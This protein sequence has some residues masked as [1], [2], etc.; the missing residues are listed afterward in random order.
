MSSSNSNN[1]IDA[2][3]GFV[4]YMNQAD[5]IQRCTS[6]SAPDAQAPTNSY[7][8]HASPMAPET[9]NLK[10]LSIDQVQEFME[11][12]QTYP[13]S[14]QIKT[15][16][17][18]AWSSEEF[19]IALHER[20]GEMCKW[21][22]INEEQKKNLYHLIHQRDHAI[23]ERIIII[24]NDYAETMTEKMD[25]M[26]ELKAQLRLQLFELFELLK[27]K[28]DKETK[29]AANV[30]LEPFLSARLP[31]KKTSHKKGAHIL[32]V[33][34]NN[35]KYMFNLPL[36]RYFVEN[37]WKLE[38]PDVIISVTGGVFRDFDL[39]PDKHDMFMRGM[40][41]GTRKLKPWSVS[42]YGC[43]SLLSVCGSCIVQACCVRACCLRLCQRTP[44]A[45]NE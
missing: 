3:L 35:K 25:S 11:Q 28:L 39:H 41:E 7:N 22:L 31:F 37:V 38:R 29:W 1:R 40:M 12:L 5:G 21:D 10:D 30:K 26:G 18:R 13:S 43:I 32:Q 19:Q 17:R 4:H 6:S 15:F 24:G 36:V 8:S 42:I 2:H 23:I 33:P 45:V 34:C 44:A 16:R 9:E 14:E 27:A 20:V